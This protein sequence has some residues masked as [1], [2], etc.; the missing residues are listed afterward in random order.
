MKKQTVTN[1]QS[2]H[3][4]EQ[5]V[6]NWLRSQKFTIL[7]TNW[8]TRRCEIDIIASHSQVLYFVEV[9]ARKSTQWG[10]G[11]D[12]VTARKLAQMKFAAEYWLAGNRWDGDIRLAVVSVDGNTM[13]FT[14]ITD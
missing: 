7:E 8:K 6:A 13:H 9:K 12:Y 11:I 4:A 10:S 2:G 14:E 1:Y 3:D 5:D